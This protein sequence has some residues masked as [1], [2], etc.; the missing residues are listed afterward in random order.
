[1]AEQFYDLSDSARR[2]LHRAYIRHMLDQL[3][4]GNVIHLLSEEYTGP[5]HF[6]QFWIDT[7]GEWQKETGRDVLVGLSATK[8]VQDAILSDGARAAVVDIIDIRYWWYQEN[9]DVY[10]PPGGQNLAPRQ[11]ARVLKPKPT[12]ADQVYRAVREYRSKYPD[13]AVMYSADAADKHGWAVLMAGGSLATLKLADE[14]ARATTAMRPAEPSQRAPDWVLTDES[15][16]ALR[17]R[18]GPG[19]IDLAGKVARRIDPRT[20]AVLEGDGELL[21]IVPDRSPR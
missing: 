4:G 3:A 12:S 20:G 21:W 17:Y 1:M 7:I 18:R 9:G 5:L 19:S 6:M 13:K 14:V 10:A 16:A 11:W 8:D 15:G 2:A